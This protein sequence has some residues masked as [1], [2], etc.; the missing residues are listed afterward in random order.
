MVELGDMV[1]DVLTGFKGR[2]IARA[3]YLYGCVQ[4]LI[5]PTVNEKGELPENAWV[6]EPQLKVIEEWG[7]DPE[8]EKHGGDRPHPR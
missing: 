3:T 2:A 7:K 6:D 8:P 5:Q 1:E 4:L